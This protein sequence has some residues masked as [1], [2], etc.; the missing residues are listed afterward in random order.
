MRLEVSGHTAAVLWNVTFRICLKTTC[1][2][3]VE[4]SFSFLVYVFHSNQF[5]SLF[6]GI[7]TFCRLF[8]AKTIFLEEQ[9]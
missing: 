7:S 2:I 4:F 3:L 6:N 1:S 8:N 9:K 5:F